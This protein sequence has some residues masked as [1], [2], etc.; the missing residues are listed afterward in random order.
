FNAQR[1]YEWIDLPSN[2]HNG[3][4]GFAFADGHS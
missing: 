2:Q 1:N 4:C 3:A